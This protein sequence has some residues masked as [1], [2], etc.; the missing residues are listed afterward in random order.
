MTTSSR[1]EQMIDIL[2]LVLFWCCVPWT[3]LADLATSFFLSLHHNR[4]LASVFGLAF[5]GL[6]CFLFTKGGIMCVCACVCDCS[7][8]SEK[9]KLSHPTFEATLVIEVNSTLIE[10]LST[11]CTALFGC[12]F[13]CIAIFLHIC[14][15][16]VQ[17]AYI[18]CHCVAGFSREFMLVFCA[19]WFL[20]IVCICTCVR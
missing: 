13:A 19:C 14:V 7:V 9:L 18:S 16:I 20:V 11:L 3:L 15:P 2:S 5:A 1:F 17:F 12:F 8:A 10:L 6:V 4:F